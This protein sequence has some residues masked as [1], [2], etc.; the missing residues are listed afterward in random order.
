MMVHFHDTFDFVLT[1]SIKFLYLSQ[2]W[3]ERLFQEMYFAYLRNRSK[4]D[5]SV[6]WYD[7]EIWFFDNYVIPLAYKLKECGVFGVSGDEYLGYAVQNRSE[8][9]EKGRAS[10]DAMKQRAMSKAKKMG[11]IRKDIA[12]D[13]E[14]A[15][16]TMDSIVEEGIDGSTHKE[17]EVVNQLIPAGLEAPPGI[18]NLVVQGQVVH[19]VDSGSS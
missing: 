1:F 12:D 3:N 7:G 8:W 19:E 17:F 18:L 2:K 9:G 6:G 13:V 5:P 14:I 16:A 4:K 10:V 15:P 11:L